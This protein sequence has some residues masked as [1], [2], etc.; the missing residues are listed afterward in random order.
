MN[1]KSPLHPDFFEGSYQIEWRRLGGGNNISPFS[2]SRS[3]FLSS[4]PTSEPSHWSYSSIAAAILRGNSSKRLERKRIVL[5][6][7]LSCVETPLSV[8][9]G[10]ALF[11][12]IP[13]N[14]KHNSFAMTDLYLRGHKDTWEDLR[15]TRPTFVKNRLPKLHACE[16][17]M[18]ALKEELKQRDPPYITAHELVRVVTWYVTP[19]T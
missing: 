7:L 17:D 9:K 18:K 15:K 12:S 1:Y 14:S 2:F 13:T 4:E 3:T 6:L 11:C 5:P 16:E 19:P 8:W 10:S